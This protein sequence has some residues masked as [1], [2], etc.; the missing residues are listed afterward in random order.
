M[1]MDDNICFNSVAEIEGLLP[2]MNPVTAVYVAKTYLNKIPA[3]PATAVSEDEKLRL[4]SE[5]PTYPQT[6]SRWFHL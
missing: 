3:L 1:F 4:Y 6:S 5:G 2:L